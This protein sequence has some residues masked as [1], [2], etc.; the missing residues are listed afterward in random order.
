MARC[1]LCK[2]PDLHFYSEGDVTCNDYEGCGWGGAT[3]EMLEAEGGFEE[4]LPYL[5]ATGRLEVR[6]VRRHAW[7]DGVY[8]Y[9]DDGVI[10]QVGSLPGG[11]ATLLGKDLLARDWYLVAQ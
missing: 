2:S 10:A 7:P 6:R 5:R 11:V 9:G 3:I 1:P 4:V 8:L